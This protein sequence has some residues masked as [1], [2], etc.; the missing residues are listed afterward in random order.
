MT[1]EDIT[2]FGMAYWL[3]KRTELC[4]QTNESGLYSVINYGACK[5]LSETEVNNH[6]VKMCI[7]V[8]DSYNL[9]M[10]GLTYIS[11]YLLKV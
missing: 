7:Q 2:L 4:T 8:R 5:G 11:S 10:S 3:K 1:L 6:I 9:Q